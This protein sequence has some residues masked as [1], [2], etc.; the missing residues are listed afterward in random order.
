MTNKQVSA[1][2]MPALLVSDCLAR[3]AQPTRPSTE[4]FLRA[5]P[6]TA[7]VEVTFANRSRMRGWVGES[8]RR[9]LRVPLH[10]RQPTDKGARG[11]QRGP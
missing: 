9:Q 6:P 3:T 1:V 5:L 4:E 2:A 11:V 8:V 7:V 10:R